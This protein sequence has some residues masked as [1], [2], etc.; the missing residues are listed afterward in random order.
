MVGEALSVGVESRVCFPEVGVGRLCCWVGR[1]AMVG[2]A[3]SVGCG[4]PLGAY[5]VDLWILVCVEWLCGWVGGGAMEARS[6]G[7]NLPLGA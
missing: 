1:C 4:L 6:V 5:S 3:R 2:E 7:C